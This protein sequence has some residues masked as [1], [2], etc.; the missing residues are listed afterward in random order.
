M[1]SGCTAHSIASLLTDIPWFC[2]N[3]QTDWYKISRIASVT[4]L[5]HFFVLFCCFLRKSTRLTD[6]NDCNRPRVLARVTSITS[7]S[8]VMHFIYFCKI[9]N[10]WGCISFRW[11]VMKWTTCARIDLWL[12]SGKFFVFN[13]NAQFDTR[14]NINIRLTRLDRTVEVKCNRLIHRQACQ[15]NCRL[16]QFNAR[17]RAL[18][19]G[20]WLSV[21]AYC[22]LMK[23]K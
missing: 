11:N 5:F 3:L 16:I 14:S 2:W 8:R 19:G 23:N 21:G 13:N 4:I 18:N 20:G 6:I 15:S 12:S 10:T 1:Y 7:A 17:Y 22:V 9:I